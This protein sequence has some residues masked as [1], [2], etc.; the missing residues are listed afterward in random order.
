MEDESL[1]GAHGTCVNIHGSFECE[2]SM[3]FIATDD[4]KACKGLFEL[5]FKSLASDPAIASCYHQYLSKLT[6][7]K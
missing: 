6:L 3:G 4:R 7:I 5:V 1:C 2:C